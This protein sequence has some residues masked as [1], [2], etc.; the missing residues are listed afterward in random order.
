VTEHSAGGRPASAG[1]TAQAWAGRHWH[2]VLL[3]LWTVS[4]A[5]DIASGGGIAWNFFRSGTAALFGGPG[6]FRPPGGLDLYA[7]NPSLQI[8]P[9]S[10]TVAEILRQLGPDN[11][12]VTAE[13]LL[14]AAGIAVIAAIENLA[15]RVRPELTEQPRTLQLTVLVGGAAFMVAW[16]D[17]AVGYLHLDDG[18]ALILAVAALRAVIARRP[19]L[20]G[21]YVGLAAD[22]KPWALVFLAVLFL[23]PARDFWRGALATLAVIAAAWLPFYLADPATMAAAHYTIRNMPTSA[24]RAIGVTA[25]QT[26]SWD[27]P[28][29]V[30]LGWVLGAVAVWRR[31]WAA[32]ILLGVGARIGLDPG[33]HGYYTAGV[34]VGALIW[35]TIGARRPCPL[36][37]LLC[38]FALSAIPIM[39]RDPQVLGDARLAVV[40]AFTATVLL[41]PARWVWPASRHPGVSGVPGVPGPAGRGSGRGIAARLR[42]RHGRA[43]PAIGAARG[44]RPGRE[45]FDRR[46][47]GKLS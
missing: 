44:T 30:L 23:L 4:W 5:V 47:A 36:A 32:I 15:R 29:Q 42:T 1:R 27:R 28:A 11:G 31:R 6:S 39:T 46:S 2:Y 34:M 18:L 25:A 17:L 13:I 21:A 14:A 3:S 22:A 38:I 19:V 40:V 37:S 45:P 43:A 12:L 35:D 20:A 33:V 24:L 8:G 10:F 26:P 16:V 9:L 41:M 7:S